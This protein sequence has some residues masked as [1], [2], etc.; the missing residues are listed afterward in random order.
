MAKTLNLPKHIALIPDG[1]RRWAKARNLKPW[2]GHF[3]GL[4]NLE[5]ILKWSVNNGILY[6]SFWGASIDNVLKRDKKEVDFLMK[7]FESEFKKLSKSKFIKD[8]KIKIN[9]IGEWEQYFPTNT[10]LAIKQCIT[11]T[12]DNDKV[13]ANFFLA[14]SGTKEILDCIK[15]ISSKN[16]KEITGETIKQNLLTKDLPPVDLLI[17]TGGEPHNSDGFLMWDT[18]NSQYIFL[19]KFWPDFNAKDFAK[20]IKEYQKRER[21]LGK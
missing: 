7:I 17:R 14:Y 2:M 21:R 20:A 6:T 13:F 10:V 9:V 15:N 18:A 8:N 19:K 4:K 5:E 11:A 3:H 1:N 16:I 12:K